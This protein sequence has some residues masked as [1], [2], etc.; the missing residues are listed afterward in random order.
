MYKEA[1]IRN[2]E[3]KELYFIVY[4][5][6]IRKGDGSLEAKEKA[7]CAIE[8]RY[9]LGKGRVRNIMHDTIRV[10][11]PIYANMFRERNEQLM[12]LMEDVKDETG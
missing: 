1:E 10:N 7:Y 8:L 4:K 11:S 12:E 6:A 3:I 2:Y 5:R 9:S